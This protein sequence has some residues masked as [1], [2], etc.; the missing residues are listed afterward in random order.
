MN[1]KRF[2]DYI[3]HSY[4]GDA[5]IIRKKARALLVFNVVTII[6]LIFYLLSLPFTTQNLQDALIFSAAIVILTFGIVLIRRHRF[7]TSSLMTI[8]LS[9]VALAFSGFFPKS[10]TSY[11]IYQLALLLLFVVIVSMLVYTKRYQIYM[12]ELLGL[13]AIIAFY[14]SRYSLFTESPELRVN[15]VI[16]AVCIYGLGSVLG[17]YVDRIL[18]DSVKQAEAE[19]ALNLGKFSELARL[20]TSSKEGL[21]IGHRLKSVA[22]NATA[23]A[24]GIK[25]SLEGMLAEVATL[26]NR[27]EAMADAN[28]RIV[29]A[30]GNFKQFMENQN[31]SVS[32]SSASISEMN[33]SISSMASVADKKLRKMK[34]LVDMAENAEAEMDRSR[35]AMDNLTGKA[36][37]VLSITKVIA[38]IAAQTNL[39]AMN[40]A[41]EAAHAGDYG[42][43]FAVV[44][45]EIRKLAENSKANLKMITTTIKTNIKD[46][47]DAIAINAREREYFTNMSGEVNEFARALDEIGTGLME[48]SH[49]ATDIM[50]AVTVMTNES[51]QAG[52]SAANI[53]AMISESD[54]G[55]NRVG[56]FIGTLSV[57]SEKLFTGYASIM[58]EI[59]AVRGMCDENISYIEDLTKKIEAISHS[60]PPDRS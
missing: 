22:D 45:D 32:E 18:S 52:E 19:A 11:T 40:A 50:K 23:S 14:A 33:A 47:E 31:V 56:E 38:T 30:T 37:D 13:L 7:E 9:F 1:I 49:G 2:F 5:F 6:F 60:A 43:G 17:L 46:I 26:G 57:T 28:G 58:K 10:N 24:L 8:I 36:N 20:V 39:L 35:A 21:L 59:E 44:A 54:A 15:A 55:I 12:I 42:R 41:I 4:A 3:L 51:G 53:H 27:V 34:S 29:A 48:L 16:S 25:S